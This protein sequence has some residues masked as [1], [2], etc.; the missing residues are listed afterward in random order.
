M[1]YKLSSKT[2]CPSLNFERLPWEEREKRTRSSRNATGKSAIT[3]A[4]V[5][6]TTPSEYSCEEDSDLICQQTTATAM[7]MPSVHIEMEI[8]PRIEKSAHLLTV[9]L[10]Y[11]YV[12]FDQ[13][14]K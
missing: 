5:R 4:K 10:R 12:I 13:M 14:T 2:Q 8:F 6:D 11:L 7:K 3:R 1:C 9:T